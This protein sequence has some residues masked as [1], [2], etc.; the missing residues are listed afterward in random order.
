MKGYVDGVYVLLMVLLSR[1]VSGGLV[2]SEIFC[3]KIEVKY[4][5]CFLMVVC[6]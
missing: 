4:L 5:L 3:V 6:K 2:L 1:A